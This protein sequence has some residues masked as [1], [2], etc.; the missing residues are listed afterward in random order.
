MH[1][2][3]SSPPPTLTL[4]PGQH[5]PAL[6]CLIRTV[7]YLFPWCGA[8]AHLPAP[9]YSAYSVLRL[10]PPFPSV[11][12]CLS[13]VVPFR[14]CAGLAFALPRLLLL[15]LPL[16]LLLLCFTSRLRCR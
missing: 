10:C 4:P 12:F 9:A 2:S 8:R 16:L 5:H 13:V 3:Y 1:L 15:P 6:H 11:P 7:P 14:L